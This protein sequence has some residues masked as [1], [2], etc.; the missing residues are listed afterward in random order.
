MRIIVIDVYPHGVWPALQRI[1]EGLYGN[2][3]DLES[4][5][6]CIGV[7]SYGICDS[8]GKFEHNKN[9]H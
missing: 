9:M 8:V 1:S 7:F 5:G 6:L 2:Q 3:K 4:H